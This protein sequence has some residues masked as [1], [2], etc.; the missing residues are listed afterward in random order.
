M[1]KKTTTDGLTV[2]SIAMLFVAIG[3]LSSCKKARTCTCS[4]ASTVIETTTSSGST[5]TSTSSS[6]DSYTSVSS[7]KLSK[8][9]ANAW[10]TSEINTLETTATGSGQYAGIRYTENQSRD[11]NCTLK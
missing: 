10:C 6:A 11:I 7:T 3:L 8:K 1:K 9:Q 4:E 2:K 5:T